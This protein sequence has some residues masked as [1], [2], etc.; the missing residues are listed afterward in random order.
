MNNLNNNLLLSAGSI[1]G[2][3]GK[4]L[5]R[6]EQVLFGKAGGRFFGITA[7]GRERRRFLFFIVFLLFACVFRKKAVTLQANLRIRFLVLSFKCLRRD[8]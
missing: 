7:G 1:G 4:V 2:I 6:L 8:T 5:G 3:I